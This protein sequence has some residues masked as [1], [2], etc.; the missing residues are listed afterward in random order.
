MKSIE[1]GAVESALLQDDPVLVELAARS[2]GQTL[3]RAVE[4]IG[5]SFDQ[6]ANLEAADQP[7]PD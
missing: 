6:L 4:R 5:V 7:L 1:P 3:G 2:S